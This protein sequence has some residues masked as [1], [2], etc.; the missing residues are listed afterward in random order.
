MKIF[1]KKQLQLQNCWFQQTL[2]DY[3]FLCNH[4]WNISEFSYIYWQISIRFKIFVIFFVCIQHFCNTKYTYDFCK[5]KVNCLCKFF[6][7][8]KFA[9]KFA[10]PLSF[11]FA[12]LI[13]SWLIST[14]SIRIM[15][16]I[17]MLSCSSCWKIFFLKIQ[18]LLK[19]WWDVWNHINTT[20]E[21][22]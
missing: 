21:K 1:C 2:F 6:N 16:S 10:M 12:W 13:E 18:V 15:M 3:I 20:I 8:S 5:K 17:G 4:R 22:I 7:V 19:L 9:S 14:I 11:Q